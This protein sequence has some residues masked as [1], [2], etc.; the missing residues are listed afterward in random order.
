MSSLRFILLGCV[1]SVNLMMPAAHSSEE[2]GRRRA[3]PAAQPRSENSNLN[4]KE[5]VNGYCGQTPAGAESLIKKLSDKNQQTFDKIERLKEKI[6]GEIAALTILKDTQRMKAEYLQK[7]KDASDKKKDESVAESVKKSKEVFSHAMMLSSLS[8]VLNDK[9]GQSPTAILKSKVCIVEKFKNSAMCALLTRRTNTRDERSFYHLDETISKLSKAK[10]D[11]LKQR[12]Q[13]IIS[14]IPN[15]FSPDIMMALIDSKPNLK[16]LADKD[17]ALSKCMN[18]S[19]DFECVRFFGDKKNSQEMID[20]LIDES[21][22]VADHLKPHTEGLNSL[23][24][25]SK[26]ELEKNQELLAQENDKVDQQLRDMTVN[27]LARL[28]G[29]STL[30]SKHRQELQAQ[31]EVNDRDKLIATS[32]ASINSSIDQMKAARDDEFAAIEAFKVYLANKYLCKCSGASQAKVESSTSCYKLGG[33]DATSTI[34]NLS[35]NVSSI[36]KSVSF[37]DRL[38]NECT[39]PPEKI[40]ALNDSCKRRGEQDDFKAVCAI[41]AGE[42]KQHERVV[43]D[44]KAWD[45]LNEKNWIVR[46]S[47]VKGGLRKIP[48]KTTMQLIG[49]GVA[50]AIPTLVPMW[51]ANYQMSNQIDMLTQQAIAEKQY[52]HTIGMYNQN[53]WMYSMPYFQGGY[54]PTTFTTRPATT[55]NTGFNFGTP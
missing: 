26:I 25:E 55:T 50:P 23:I 4:Y 43:S 47:S 39:P 36:L 37:S 46:D 52:Y 9:S 18:G 15:E 5:D 17:D 49:E 45:K 19:S 13:E 12:A 16:K 35:G 2:E 7:I 34:F 11:N 32:N 24:A 1:L 30:S 31:C 48:K 3:A 44:N 40:L 54:L 8:V 53:P 10:A 41:V 21:N 22:Q 42:S 27:C 6:N 33:S 20:A 29:M 51:F 14:S 38:Q 28:A